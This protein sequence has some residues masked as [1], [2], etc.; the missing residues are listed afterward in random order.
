LKSVV[1]SGVVPR[2]VRP[3]GTE[4]S[5]VDTLGHESLYDYDPVWAACHE[6]RVAPAFHGIGYSW[7]SRVSSSNYVHN[8]IGNFAAAQEAVCRSLV[9]GGVA[10]RFPEL[11]FTFLEGG[12][13]W[14]CQ[15][16]ADLLGHFE[17]R[18]RDQVHAYDDANLDIDLAVSLFEQYARGRVTG[19][20]DRFTTVMRRAAA[21]ARA[22]DESTETD[23][24]ADAAITTADDIVDMFTRQFAFGCEADDPMNA[25]AFERGKLPRGARLAAVFASDIGPWDVPDARDV[26]PEAW[27]LV[28]HGHLDEADFAEFTC[29][30]VVRTLTALNPGFFAGTAIEGV[31]N[32]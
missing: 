25:L 26:L 5:W 22:F 20:A 32:M 10:R 21:A 6:T 24:F 15:L 9:M 8:H 14:A 17:K 31:G 3:D 18:N 29:G 13:S 30:N 16:Y 11:R 4:T 23:D 28:E 27:E 1:M 19:D 2:P 7:G 12:V